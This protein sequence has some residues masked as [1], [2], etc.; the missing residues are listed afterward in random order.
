M[1]LALKETSHDPIIYTSALRKPCSESAGELD[2]VLFLSCVRR[3]E[4]RR[5][6]AGKVC[7]A[8]PEKLCHSLTCFVPVC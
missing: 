6:G 5:L 3:L 1:P 2:D 8:E 7:S 4:I